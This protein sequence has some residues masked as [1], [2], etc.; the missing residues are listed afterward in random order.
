[1]GPS[2]A[3]DDVAA[4]TPAEFRALVAGS[5][6]GRGYTRVEAVVGG[7]DRGGDLRC[8]DA[9]GRLVLVHVRRY[10]PAVKVGS[11]TIRQLDAMTA[12]HLAVRAV[13]VTTS[14]FTAPARAMAAS[15][16]VDLVDGGALAA[17]HRSTHPGPRRLPPTPKPVDPVGQPRVGLRPWLSGA[18]RKA[19]GG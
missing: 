17:H 16:G 15:L 1:M 6:E 8:R 11:L 13:C 4:L 2:P 9:L 7:G 19:R 10:P 3:V 14:E 18:W 12:R 5:L